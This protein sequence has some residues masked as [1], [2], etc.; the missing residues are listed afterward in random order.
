MAK[1]RYE[2]DTR[3]LTVFFLVAMPF[4]AF[5]SFL[6]VN[7]ARGQLQNSI[8][9]SLEQ[10]AL[11]TKLSLE[12]YIAEQIGQL[13]LV[14]I[15]ADVRRSLA[16]AAG[17]HEPTADEGRRLE[18]AWASG[19]DPQLMAP[20]LESP[21]ARYLRETAQVRPAFKLIQVIDGKGRLLASSMRG[22]RLLH[23]DTAWFQALARDEGLGR[24]YV[25]DLYRQPGSSMALFEIAYPVRAEGRWTGAVRALVEGADLYGV[26]APVRIGRT[27]HAVLVRS[28]DGLVLASDDA[29]RDFR[30]RFPGFS[31]IQ[32]AMREKRGYWVIPEV[33]E[34]ADEKSA[35]VEP[36]R[37]VGY[38]P[39][40]QVPGVQWLVTVEQDVSEAMA[41]IAGITRYLWMHF[42]G[43]FGTVIL[44]ALYF[45]FKLEMPVIEEEL[46]LH[47]EHV[48]TGTRPAV[49]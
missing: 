32:T 31:L 11:T 41:P 26:L 12:R 16:G 1:K 48:P 49:G 24:P 8:G 20:L 19:S 40:D 28:G 23:Q 27:G 9:E 37:L 17:A 4:V 29:N 47:E 42:I 3:V 6:V 46:H 18:Q 7:M 34:T 10:R 25:G 21:L 45:S 2:L 15:D 5:G 44:L 14:S 39:V 30:K 22:G 38:A 33:R 36:A 13:R 43:V 35:L